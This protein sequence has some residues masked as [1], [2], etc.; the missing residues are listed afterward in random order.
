MDV[1]VVAA[2]EAVQD[3]S[4]ITCASCVPSSVPA[5]FMEF[6]NASSAAITKLRFSAVV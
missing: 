6:W 4:P 3:V 5:A 1:L 2:V